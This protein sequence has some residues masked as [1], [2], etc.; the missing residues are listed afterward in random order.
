MVYVTATNLKANLSRYLALANKEDIVITKNGND[1]AVITAPKPKPSI[2]DEL[3]GIIPDDGI[4]L[5]KAREERFSGY[6]SN[7]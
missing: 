3:I 2:V 1:I 7:N 5:K 6:E 4:D